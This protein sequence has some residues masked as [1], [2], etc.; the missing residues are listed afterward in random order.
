M[1]KMD[2]A[3]RRVVHFI[4]NFCKGDCET[5]TSP[6]SLAPYRIMVALWSEQPYL[7]CT[8]FM[9]KLQ[10]ALLERNFGQN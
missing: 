10:N 7:P 6:T 2:G 1:D 9:K 8:N 4:P 5:D 3:Q